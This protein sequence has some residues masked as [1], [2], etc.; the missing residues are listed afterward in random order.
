MAGRSVLIVGAGLGGLAT[1]IGLRRAGF[2]VTVFEQATELAPAGFG[3]GI[4][5][6]G[7]QA[8]DLLGAYQRVAEEG[9]VPEVSH[10]KTSRGNLIRTVAVKEMGEKSGFPTRIF[11][12]AD[13]QRALLDQLPPEILHLGKRCVGIE[14]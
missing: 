1:A 14:N 11:H 2:D 8:L 9:S 10:I 4:T 7:L 3:I 12:R 13:L 5:T 6:N